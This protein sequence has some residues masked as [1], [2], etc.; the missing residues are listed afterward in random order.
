MKKQKTRRMSIRWKITIPAAFIVV[1]IAVVMGVNSYVAVHNGMLEMGVEEA[2]MAARIAAAMVDGD[3]LETINADSVGSDVYNQLYDS[4]VSVRDDCGIKYMYTIY[5]DGSS[6]YYSIDTDEV[7]PCAYGTVLETSYEEVKG[8]F[9]GEEYIQNYIVDQGYGEVITAYLP[10]RNSAGEVVGA[11]GCDY[12]A[13]NVTERIATTMTRV[14]IIAVICLVLAIA[15]LMLVINAIIKSLRRVD[16][17]IYD[18]VHNEGDL[19]Q[20]LDVHTGDEMEL[21]AD[22]VNALLEHIREI[23]LNISKNSRFLNGSSRSVVENLSDAELSIT[24]VS[25]TMEQMSAA[26]QETNA[27][28]N[29]INEAIGQTYQ[30]LEGIYNK[31]EAG[32]SSS[33]DIMQ[34]ASEIYRTAE[35]EQAGAKEEAGQMALAV[36]EKIEKSKAVEQI[37]ELTANI[38][39][40]TEQTNLLSLNA[41][42][43]AARAGEAGRGFAVVAD[44]I[45]K[46]AMNSAEAATQIRSVSAD[47]I[48]AVN[49]LAMEAEQMLTFMN[50]TAMGGYNKLLE[51]SES[52]RGDVED[53]SRMMQEFA[54][55]SEQLKINMDSIKEAVEAVNI[56]VDESTV[57][58]TNVTEKSVDLTNNVS[59]IGQEANTNMD[60]A[61]ELNTEVGKFKLE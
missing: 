58:V 4:M 41:S 17:K 5:T 56:A 1:M 7:N 36:Q 2:Q 33:E 51:T 11:V 37:S 44:E 8:V 13:A 43:E 40:I 47:V 61:S 32:S 23:M 55:Q 28:L 31:A 19:T 22:N 9:S 42:I 18:L 24:D 34:K 35:E 16:E 30:S 29:Q 6:A 45:G 49:E 14:I 50:E 59:E 52:Y 57:G 53:M 39:N 15:V 46:L 20:K 27:S 26:M 38:I 54:E 21:I 48:Q 12:D 10:V 25:S 3:A 60:I